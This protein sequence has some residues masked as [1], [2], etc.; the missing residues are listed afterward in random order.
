M[1]HVGE[2][3]KKETL[4][5][6]YAGLT[7]WSFSGHVAGLRLEHVQRLAF[8]KFHV[9]KCLGNCRGKVAPRVPGIDEGRPEDLKGTKYDWLTHPANMSAKQKARFQQLRTSDIKE[10]ALHIMAHRARVGAMVVVGHAVRLERHGVGYPQCD[11]P[12][13]EQWPCG[14]HQQQDQNNQSAQ[15]GLPQQTAEEGTGFATPFT[16]TSEAGTVDNPAAS[17]GEFTH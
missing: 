4:T 5:R 6:W 15:Q 3:R 10:M 17:A 2:D 8:D 1:L 11:H 12:E 9:V 14:G 7:L 16:F 13:G